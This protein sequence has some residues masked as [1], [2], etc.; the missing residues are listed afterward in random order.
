MNSSMMKLSRRAGGIQWA[1]LMGAGF[2]AP[3]AWAVGHVIGT[4]T[5][6]TAA[7]PPADYQVINGATLTG[8]GANLTWA[9]V[10]ASHLVLS[11]GSVSGGGHLAIELAG[12]DAQLSGVQVQS[13]TTA[14][15]IGS[16]STAQV[17]G[18][19]LSGGEFGAQ[20]GT[21]STLVVS[22]TEVTGTEFAGVYMGAGTLSASE[23]SISGGE[24]G[25]IIED[26]IGGGR[27]T[28]TLS[29]TQV[30]AVT[31]PAIQVGVPLAGGYKGNADITLSNGATLSA[32]NGTLV[33]LTDG[34]SATVGVTNSSLE[35][36]FVA[37]ENT[38]LALSLGQ[39]ASLVGDVLAG[40]GS[41]AS[42]G[43]AD[44][45]QFTGRLEGVNDL[46]IA[47]GATWTLISDSTQAN[48]TL[49]GGVVKLGEGGSYRTLTVQN[50]SGGGGQFEL[51]TDFVTGQ[52]DFVD[53]TG[54]SS[55]DHV[56]AVASS[57]TD[58]S[59]THIDVARTADG[60][61]TFSLLNGRVDVGTWSYQLASD[62]GEN[63]YL[64]GSEG[65]VS[66]GAASALALFNTAPTV[67]YGELT[68]LRSRMGELRWRSAAPGAWVRSYGN[69]YNVTTGSGVG[70]RQQQQGLSLGADAPLPWGDGQ[71]IAGVLAGYSQSDL[72]LQQGTN[73]TV[74]SY[75]AGAYAT[76]LDSHSGYYFDALIKANRFRNDADVALSD[77]SRT[78]GGYNTFGIGASAEFGRHIELAA[79]WFVEPYA[80]LSSLVVQGRDFTL[81]NGLAADGERA[82][83]LVGKVGATL[84][85]TLDLGGGRSVQPYVRTAI[86]HEFARR[87]EVT[88]ND[89]RFNNDL[90]G[91]RGEV[92]VGIAVNL[93][94]RFQANA[95]FDYAHGDALEQPWG[96]NA[97]LRYNW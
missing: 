15:N 89:N 75:Y 84:G 87:N 19:S 62:D 90:A 3:G 85:R 61:A 80:Q 35:G 64:D 79:G 47:S 68:T 83:S 78:D 2:T 9:Q 49:D 21:G 8:N 88:V 26:A 44:G 71:W 48:L 81:D 92:G 18:G 1:I 20:I 67:W 59:Q 58:A 7:S 22:G 27:A 55:G 93:G 73:G 95:G 14:L 16:T 36:N 86:A 32:G 51:H 57:G 10:R 28:V 4:D 70:Y 53:I 96:V 23:G 94:N 60:G 91:S 97:G 41:T 42:L 46:S 43:M 52:T 30:E 77:G 13:D 54:S 29:G 65:I 45:A 66:P 69:K 34:S 76:W 24:Y 72:D 37:G 11:G 50:L 17:S 40:A 5:T 63:W 33:A 82:R 31:G 56:L 38:S 39:G 25:M 74:K 6:I 12:S